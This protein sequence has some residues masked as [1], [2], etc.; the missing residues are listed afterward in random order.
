MNLTAFLAAKGV[1]PERIEEASKQ[2]RR[3]LL[4]LAIDQL[5]LPSKNYYTAA[6]A[7]EKARVDPELARRLRRAMGF[8]DPHEF[9]PAYTKADIDA[10][11]SLSRLIDMGVTDPEIAVQMTRVMGQSLAKVAEAQVTTAWE[12]LSGPLSASGLEDDEVAETITR[13]ITDVIPFIEEFV[14]YIWRRHLAE[15]AKGSL[16]TRIAG[17]RPDQTMAIGFCDIAG[18]T[19]LSQELEDL[20]LARTVDRFESGAYDTIAGEGGRVVK[21]IG[22]EVMF[23][24]TAPA[25]AA[26]IGLKLAHQFAEDEMVPEVRVGLAYGPALP[27]EGDFLGS[28]VNLA[29]RIATIA[30]PSSV[31][32]S[33]EFASELGTNGAFRAKPIRTPYRLK[34]IGRVRLWVLRRPDES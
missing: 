26:E 31:V 18:F 11:R 16:A 30:Q 10:L 12:R 28:T 9:E 6:E 13:L 24:T 17:A 7:A 22:D 27:R 33:D 15:A 32:V 3:G 29:S 21:V 19:R 34:G 2:G 25:A 1:A 23:V 8:V 14:V 4:M 20:E 5:L